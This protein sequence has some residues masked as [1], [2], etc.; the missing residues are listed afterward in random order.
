M[1]DITG[2]WGA[3]VVLKLIELGYPKKNLY[4]D[5]TVGIDSVE[6]NKALQKHMDR[7]KLPGLNFQKNRNTIV[8][9]LEEAIRMDSFKIRSKRA[10]MEI[11]TFV[12]IGGRADHMKGYHDDLLMSIAMCCFV[13]ATSFKDL[14]KSKG[15]AK[16]MINSWSVEV[17]NV[18]DESSLS[19]VIN[20][21]FYTDNKGRKK[22]KQTIKETQEHMWLFNGMAGFK[23]N[24]K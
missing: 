9:K 18:E 11:E 17:N 24:R 20:T 7:G 2:G 4:Y 6:N 23:K 15:Q 1:V 19:D 12:F 5:I 13:A 10:L 22:D 21:G 3:S 16:A 14:E 8:S